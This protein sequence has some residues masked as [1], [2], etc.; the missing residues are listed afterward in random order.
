MVGR[1]IEF[2]IGGW[3]NWEI[4]GQNVSAVKGERVLR[5][6]PIFFVWGLYDRYS[7]PF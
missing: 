1:K 6:E 3:R 7:G 4:G 5:P 2:L